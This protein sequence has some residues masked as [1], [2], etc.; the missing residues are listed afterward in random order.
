ML[1][2]KSVIYKEY[3]YGAETKAPHENIFEGMGWGYDLMSSW[4]DHI[5]S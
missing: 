5:G 2:I 4:D 3:K 1:V